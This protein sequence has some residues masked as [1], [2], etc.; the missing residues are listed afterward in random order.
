M[1]ERAAVASLR[2][3]SPWPP[4]GAGPEGGV[5]LQSNVLEGSSAPF[6]LDGSPLGRGGV[7]VVV[8]IRGDESVRTVL[9]RTHPPAPSRDDHITEG[10]PIAGPAP[11]HVVLVRPG[12]PALVGP[13]SVRGHARAA[14]EPVP[15]EP[16]RRTARGFS[17][18][19]NDPQSSSVMASMVHHG[20]NEREVAVCLRST[21]TTQPGTIIISKTTAT[22]LAALVHR[23]TILELAGV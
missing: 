15:D 18:A 19:V 14:V 3:E 6:G 1:S 2:R 8:R 23:V 17:A 21:T 22:F 13:E 20:D 7:V 12:T 9:T 4:V 10:G 11:D 5:V 16:Y